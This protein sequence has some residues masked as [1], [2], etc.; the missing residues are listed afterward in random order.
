MRIRNGTP[1]SNYFDE[2]GAENQ[3][4]GSEEFY[5]PVANLAT[6]CV[7]MRDEQGLT[8]EEL[9]QRMGTKQSVISRFENLDGRLPSY[10]FIARL[11][12]AL[13]HTPGMTLFGDFM[14]TVP[15]EQQPLV[16]DL[17]SREGTSSRAFVESLLGWALAKYQAKEMHVVAFANTAD[18]RSPVPC[19]PEVSKVMACVK[20][21]DRSAE[22]LP[23]FA[24]AV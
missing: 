23:D 3:A 12:F 18:Y 6:E 17:A 7:V 11:S 21:D 15:L 8:Q 9:A 20:P 14:A 2:H 5:L 22:I 1:L 4:P 10:D 13:G 24:K 19:V 16:K